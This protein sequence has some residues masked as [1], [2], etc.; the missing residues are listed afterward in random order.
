MSMIYCFIDNK[1]IDTDYECYC[2]N[3][4]CTETDCAL[5]NTIIDIECCDNCQRKRVN[6]DNN[7]WCERYGE[8]VI[9]NNNY[10]ECQFYIRSD[11]TLYNESEEQTQ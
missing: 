9:F 3:T 1:N 11:K 7:K 6:E 10:T 5:Y 2:E 4:T 8:N